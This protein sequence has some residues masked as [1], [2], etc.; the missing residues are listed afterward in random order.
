MGIITV[1]AILTI[2]VAVKNFVVNRIHERAAV[3]EAM[4]A[5]LAD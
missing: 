5:R 2:G 3:E 1:V 4:S